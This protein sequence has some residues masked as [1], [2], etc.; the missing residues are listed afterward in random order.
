MS[1][2]PASGNATVRVRVKDEDGEFIKGELQKQ[3]SWVRYFFTFGFIPILNT[4]A[5]KIGQSWMF[6]INSTK[7]YEDLLGEVWK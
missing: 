6:V 3:I 7:I 4:R 2:R 1:G 5:T